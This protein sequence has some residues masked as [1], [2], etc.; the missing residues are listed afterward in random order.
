MR[1]KVGRQL[2]QLEAKRTKAG[3]LLSDLPVYNRALADARQALSTKDTVEA[4][5]ALERMG[6]ELSRN[7]VDKAFIARKLARLT[8]LKGKRKLDG[9][10]GKKVHNIFSRVHATYFAGDYKTANMHLN[11]LWHILHRSSEAGR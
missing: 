2:L 5:L 3:F 10:T 8:K 4:K 7:H 11:R 6:A 1:A 9:P